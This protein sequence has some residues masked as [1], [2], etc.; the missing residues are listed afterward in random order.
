MRKPKF[1]GSFAQSGFTRLRGISVA[2]MAVA[3]IIACSDRKTEPF[4]P[5]AT[6]RSALS[7]GIDPVVK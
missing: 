5:T 6:A 3:A 1:W 2:A 7:G 4:E